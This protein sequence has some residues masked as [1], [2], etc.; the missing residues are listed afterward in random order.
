MIFEV[1]VRLLQLNLLVWEFEVS[2][3]PVD[4]EG[5]G[6]LGHDELQLLLERGPLDI[7][8]VE[9]G[10]TGLYAYLD[11]IAPC[12]VVA[13][14]YGLGETDLRALNYSSPPIFPPQID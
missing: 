2:R 14:G 8:G 5:L 9:E 4:D 3:G 13:V 6:L 11:H 7:G 1:L 12:G 10:F